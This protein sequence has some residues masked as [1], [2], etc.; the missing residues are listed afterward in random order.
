MKRLIILGTLLFCNLS[1]ST[2][3]LMPLWEEDDHFAYYR[4]LMMSSAVYRI[5]KILCDMESTEKYEILN[6]LKVIKYNLGISI[7]VDK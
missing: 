2:A 6:E 7:E 5:E 1:A 3:Q 4:I